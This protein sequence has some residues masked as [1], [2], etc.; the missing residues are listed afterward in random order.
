MHKL[1]LVEAERVMAVLQDTEDRLRLTRLI[2]EQVG[3][4]LAECLVVLCSLIG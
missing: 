2:P 3:W 4:W 1:T